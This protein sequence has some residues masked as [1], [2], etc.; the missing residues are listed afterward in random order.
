MSKTTDELLMAWQATLDALIA[1]PWNSPIA[2][3]EA[4]RRVEHRT[5]KAYRAVSAGVRPSR[6]IR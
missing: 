1:A 6:G 5:W 2:E 4:L 3:L